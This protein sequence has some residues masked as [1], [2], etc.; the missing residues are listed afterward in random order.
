MSTNDARS[1][2]VDRKA[3]QAE[4]MA[5]PDLSVDLLA[6]SYRSD[7]FPADL[8]A[9]QRD[10]SLLRY[11]KWLALA[12]RSP[13]PLAPTKDIDLFWHLHM[14]APVAYHRDC[15]AILGRLLDHDGGF[16]KGV[17]ELERLIEVY[18]ATEKL[19]TEA[20]GE[21]YCIANHDRSMQGEGMTGCWHNC[22]GRCWHACAKL[23]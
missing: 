22:Q 12:A 13:G 2:G 11:R 1:T 20:Y 6:A 5:V 14:L 9:E 15:M 8:S 21:P 23:Q 17:G 7:S 16:G 19:W 3:G 4:R 18:T 10:A